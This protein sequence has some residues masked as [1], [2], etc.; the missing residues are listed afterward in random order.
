MEKSVIVIGAGISGLSAA[1][2]ARMNGFRTSIFEMHD[3]PGG[4]CTAWQRKGYTFDI[5]MHMLTASRS[6]PIHRMWEE[7]GIPGKF[8]FHYHDHIAQIEGMGQKLN[9]CTDREKLKEQMLAISPEDA[10]LTGEF[11]RIIFGQDMMKASSLKP[12]AMRNIF[13]R[14]K[15]IPVVL[16][17][18]RVFNKYSKVTLQEFAARFKNPFLREAARFFIDA[19]GWPMPRFPMVALSGFIKNGVTEAGVPLGGSQKVVFHI[20]DLF[21]QLG[22]E[23]HYKSRVTDLIIENDRVAGIRLMDG[24]EHRADSV[25]WAGDGHT[26][27]FDILGGKYL[28][29]R[30]KNR[31]ENWIPVK[32]MVHVMIGVNMDFAE[33]PHQIIFEVE[34]P[35]TIA[36]REHRWLSLIHH[37]FDGSMAPDGKSAVEVWYDTEYAYW[38]ELA[39]DRKKYK[40]EKQ[41]ISAYTIAQLEKRWPG[42]ASK[43]EVIDVPTPATYK[44]YTGNWQGSPDGWYMTTDNLNDME[45]MRE[46]PGLEGLQMVG[47][48]TAPF[49]GTVLAALSGR[50]AVQLMCKK[51][52][53]KFVTS[54]N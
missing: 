37:S 34:D 22:G 15:V 48:W 41:R 2:Y 45:P 32:P 24:T 47:Q 5:S 29:E 36:G 27:I 49:T 33:E 46:L 3:I 54:V 28:N 19:P 21:T 53:K 14:L 16:P 50:Q 30:I 52:G 7:L 12:A 26:L 1:C 17:L 51:E 8:K 42:F 11:I 38:E 23:I 4:L 9:F 18:I 35:I 43:V 10:K 44:R 13:D 6:G 20:A 40:A 25:I 39:R 31:Y